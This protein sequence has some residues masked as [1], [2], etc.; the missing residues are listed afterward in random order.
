MTRRDAFDRAVA[1]LQEAAF[2]DDRW[3]EAAGLIDEACRIKGNTLTY[4]SG[5]SHDDMVIYL[6]RLYFRG[7]RSEEIER[8]Y[9][10]DYYRQD[11]CLP[12]LRALPDCRLTHISD[13]YT[14]EEKTSSA[15]YNEI[16]PQSDM[17]NSLRV[18][19]DGPKGSRIVWSFGD[20]TEGDVWSFDQTD[21][22]ERLLP[23]LRQF[24]RI[25]QVLADM[26]GLK[27]SLAALLDRGATGVIQ[28]DRRGRIVAMNDRA[29]H[30]LKSQ[31][32]LFDQG[33]FLCAHAAADNEKLQELLSRA[34]P[35]F[36]GR[37]AGG[38]MVVNGRPA[39]PR[40]VLHVT[41]VGPLRGEV[42]SWN[43]AALVLAVDPYGRLPVDP[44]L[45]EA[46]LGLTPAEGRVAALLAEGKTVREIAAATGRSEHTIRWH[47]RQIF[48]KQGLTRIGQ[49]VPLVRSLAGD[50]GT[51]P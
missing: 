25:R 50:S 22:I 35:R 38:S 18:R 44:A 16:L 48:E 39:L 37:G 30:M 7:E 13:L 14:A 33:G 49:L 21:T 10:D 26:D 17:Q 45:V 23:H 43:V 3:P 47:I 51:G 15:V 27:A 9:F 19:M 36:G 12:R 40:A 34:L 41:P 4:G 1:A 5:A 46:A 29:L 6:A 24:V 31:E 20:P 11:E 32:G 42:P 8:R 2:D 28:L